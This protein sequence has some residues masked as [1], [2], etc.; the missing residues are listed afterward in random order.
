MVGS[1]SFCH[2]KMPPSKLKSRSGSIPSSI[3]RA[4]AFFPLTPALQY[5]KTSPLFGM[6][7]TFTTR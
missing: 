2:L 7:S 3:K 4:Q 6:L 1:T 5:T